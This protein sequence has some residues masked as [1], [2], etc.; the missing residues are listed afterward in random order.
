MNDTESKLEQLNKDILEIQEL[1]KKLKENKKQLEDNKKR[2]ERV[3]GNIRVSSTHALKQLT[4]FPVCISIL[5]GARLYCQSETPG[6][7][8]SIS[9]TRCLI[10]ALQD[11]LEYVKE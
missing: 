3:V 4:S 11:C 5:P 2:F 10:K 9:Q 7:S 6:D 8:L 1:V